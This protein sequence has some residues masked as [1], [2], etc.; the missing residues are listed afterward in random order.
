MIFFVIDLPIDAQ[1]PAFGNLANSLGK[2]YG[3]LLGIN[4]LISESSDASILTNGVN[5]VTSAVLAVSE[6]VCG[7]S[8][9]ITSD[10][11]L[12]GINAS[13]EKWSQ[14]ESALG[15]ALSGVSDGSGSLGSNGGLKYYA[16]SLHDLAVALSGLTGVINGLPGDSAVAIGKAS[17]FY[18]LTSITYDLADGRSELAGTINAVINYP[19]NPY[20]LSFVVDAL[21]EASSAGYDLATALDN[22]AN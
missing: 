19:G 10:E 12:S 6:A 11:D 20:E 13:F 21:Q 4:G 22:A 8:S 3:V 9:A 2:T 18:G 15:E 17:E 7:V 14:S 5:D 1:L 16:S